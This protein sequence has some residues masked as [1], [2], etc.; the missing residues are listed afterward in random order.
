MAHGTGEPPRASEIAKNTPNYTETTR[1]LNYY[2][3][4]QRLCTKTPELTRLH[5]DRVPGRPRA[6]RRAGGGTERLRR[7]TESLYRAAKV[8]TLTYRATRDDGRWFEERTRSRATP[9]RQRQP[10]RGGVAVPVNYG[11]GQLNKIVYG[12]E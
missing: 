8:E 7:P 4:S 2:F 10:A 11:L 12:H 3:S 1:A 9:P 5:P 6:L